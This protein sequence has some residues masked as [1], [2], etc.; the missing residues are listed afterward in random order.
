MTLS[1]HEFNMLLEFGLLIFPSL[2][3]T[4]P[5]SLG[6]LPRASL[7]ERLVNCVANSI[8]GYSCYISVALWNAWM[9]MDH[10]KQPSWM[11]NKEV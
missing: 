6:P 4:H 1:L 9:E 3:T 7:S 5:F 11:N 8:W 10:N 2:T